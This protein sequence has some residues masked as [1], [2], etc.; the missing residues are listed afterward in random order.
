MFFVNI[1]RL[2]VSDRSLKTEWSKVLWTTLSFNSCCFLINSV[3]SVPPSN[4]AILG[5]SGTNQLHI[6]WM[7]IPDDEA[8]GAVIGRD[9]LIT[10]NTLYMY[11]HQGDGD[12]VSENKTQG[13]RPK[14]LKVNPF[15]RTFCTYADSVFLSVSMLYSL[16]S[17]CPNDQTGFSWN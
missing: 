5:L 13:S 9:E 4:V 17:W 8:N 3:P 7:K 2:A 12:L 1:I 14:S 15:F 11:R 16:R 10:R 6:R